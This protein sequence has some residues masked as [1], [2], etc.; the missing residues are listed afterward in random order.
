MWL[1]KK[2]RNCEHL[3]FSEQRLAGRKALCANRYRLFAKEG[4]TLIEILVAT[5]ILGVIGLTILTTFG[6][7][8]HVYERVQAFGGSQAE[9]LLALEEMERD[10]KNVFPMSTVAFEGDSH[11]IAFPAVIETLKI[12]DGKESV[13]PSVGR[14]SYYIDEAIYMDDV[15]KSLM[16][17]QQNYSLA[18]AGGDAQEGQGETLALIEDLA[19]EYYYYDE[20]AKTYGWQNSWSGEE[21]TLLSGVKIEMTYKDS[22]QDIVIERIVVIPALQKIIELEDEEGEEE[23][24]EGGEE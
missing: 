18:V 5:S 14:I 12:I 13:V 17:V 19:F 24:G 9:V 8:L 21:E 10:I 11:R 3:A 23:E 4:F 20:E 6:S 15:E 16:R 7:G 22:D 2:K 1:I